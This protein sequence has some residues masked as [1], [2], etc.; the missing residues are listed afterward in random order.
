VLK[1]ED[2]KVLG[3]S[4]AEVCDGWTVFCCRSETWRLCVSCFSLSRTHTHTHTHTHTLVLFVW[5]LEP[6]LEI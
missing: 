1:T 2:L 4:W 5:P 6:W 3:S